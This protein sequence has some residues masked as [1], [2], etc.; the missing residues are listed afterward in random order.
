MAAAA[1]TDPSTRDAA[2]VASAVATDVDRGLAAAE[3]AARLDRDGPNRLEEER[4]VPA[5]RRLLSQFADPLVYLLLAAAVISLVA[6]SAEGS[7]GV[8]YD[9]LVIMVVVLANAVLGFVQERRSAQAV[10]ALQRMAAANAA[11]IRDGGLAR[12]PAFDVVVGDLLV[13]AEGDAVPADARLVDGALWAAEASLTGEST[14][15]AKSPAPLAEPAEVGDRTSMVFAGTAITRGTARAIVTAT[16]MDTETGRVARLLGATESDPTPLEREI[17][18]LGRVLGLGVLGIAA[19]VIATVALTQDIS[20]LQDAVDVLLLGVALAVA[21]VP[22]GLPAIMSVVLALGV[23]RMA[24]RHAIVKDLASVE[25]LGSA[26]VICSDKTGTLTQ[27]RMAVTRIVTADG[28]A[29]PAEA[30]RLAREAVAFGALA[31]DATVAGD[32]GFEGDPTEVAFLEAERELEAEALRSGFDRVDS[33]AFSSERRRMSVL[34]THD[35]RADVLAVKGA[36]DVVLA[37]CARLRTTE[38]DIVLDPERRSGLDAAIDTLADGGMRTLAV[39][40]REAP[41]SSAQEHHEVDLTLLGVVGL[42]DPP[43]DE[44]RAAVAE[45]QAAGIRVVMI[46][47]DHPRTASAIASQLG[48]VPPG[49]PALA[50]AALSR[51]DDAA[52]AAAVEDASVFARVAP[53]HKLRIVDALQAHGEVVAMT[54]DGVNDAPALRSADIGVAMGRGGTEVAREAANMILTDDDFATIVEAVR[55]GRGILDNITRFLRFLIASNLGEV[56]AVFIG[57]VLAGWLGL[58]NASG[59]VVAP[60]LATQ[61]L[62]INLLTDLGPALAVSA[63][64]YADDLMER[65]PRRPGTPMISRRMW[66]GMAF[67]GTVMAAVTLVTFDLFLPGGLLPGS[68]DLDTARTA[69]FT[70]LVIANLTVAFAARSE[71][72]STLHRLFSNPWLW[73][74][75]GLSLAL[76]VAVVH[77]PV[78][79][80]A[81]ST[82]PLSLAQWGACAVLALAVPLAIEARKAVLRSRDRAAARG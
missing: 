67:T 3:A 9:V 14:P 56:L 43:R 70:V 27:N 19:V 41:A 68:S 78:L 2:E 49:S 24:R 4:T 38:G 10:A 55:E 75:V 62:W 69:A 52:L 82:S 31:S 45:A 48:I 61:I 65:R 23:Q 39:A 25:T 66:T 6:W 28:T 15:V 42:E 53:E 30:S 81:F 7:D 36:P 32:G 20:S 74:A 80:E 21:A 26:S 37:R 77:L 59:A 54:G 73:G 76:Q 34:A 16:A 1:V 79:N 17:A 33:V 72:R 12:V 29:S 50:G 13:L 35:D 5:W 51:M 8:P 64:P 46:T 60:L 40:V 71:T 57:V 11:V 47:G 44:A 18:R 58:R 22:E 63:E